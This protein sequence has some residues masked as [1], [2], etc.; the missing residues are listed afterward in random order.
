MTHVLEAPEQPDRMAHPIFAFVATQCGGG[1]GVDGILEAVGATRDDGPMMASCDLEL[2]RPLRIGSLYRV[3]GEF[4]SIERKE[5][6]RTGPFDLVG[7]RL[8][9][10]EDPDGAVVAHVTNEW[11]VPRRPNRAD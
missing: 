8:T 3:T 1:L 11:V 2:L 9:M 4:T 6:R 7:F 10:L 5:G